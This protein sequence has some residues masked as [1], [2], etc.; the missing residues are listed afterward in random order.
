MTAMRSYIKIIIACWLLV[1]ANAQG[2]ELTFISP[3]VESGV[4]QHLGLSDE[5]SISFA[6][7]DTITTLN[8]SHRGISDIHDLVLM[9]QLHNLDL[10][11]NMVDDLQP[12]SVLDSLEWLDLSYNN[13]KGIND[14]FY[15]TAK[16][17]TINVS[18]NHIRDFSLFGS[19]SSCHF[20]LEGTGLQLGENVPFFDVCRFV[21]D[22]SV[23]P[24][25]IYGIVRTNMDEASQ[26]ICGEE[27]IGIP[28]DSEQFKQVIQYQG[29]ATVPVIITNGELSDTTYVVPPQYIESNGQATLT[30]ETDLPEGYTINSAYAAHGT[31]TVDG[32]TMTYTANVEDDDIVQFSYYEL[33]TLRG[34][35][36]FYIRP[37]LLM[38]DV[39]TDRQVSI[40]DVMMTITKILGDMP[41]GFRLRAADMNGDGDI[42]IAD[43]MAIVSIIVGK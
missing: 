2:Q 19:M 20:T 37:S 4:R 16:D 36:R 26:L 39:N 30:L 34:I 43:I 12:L 23:S 8:L 5:E 40:A 10:S 1:S 14:L 21:C 11:D 9:P 7:L 28:S 3:E 6:Q 17:L 13:L 41:Q 42:S 15:S 29:T 27:E 32:T 22:A 18:F 31:V 33:G 24:I 35:S 25:A 38:G